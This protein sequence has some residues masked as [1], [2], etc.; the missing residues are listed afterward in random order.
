MPFP[1]IHD[2][3]GI[4]CAVHKRLWDDSSG[5]LFRSFLRFCT[6]TWL[7]TLSWELLGC[8]RWKERI[9]LAEKHIFQVYQRWF[10][11][12]CCLWLFGTSCGFFGSRWF[13]NYF[14]QHQ[15]PRNWNPAHCINR[16]AAGLGNAVLP[17]YADDRCAW[18][19]SE[20]W[21][22]SCESFFKLFY[23]S[24]YCPR[25]NSAPH[26]QLWAASSQLAGTRYTP[27]Y[28]GRYRYAWWSSCRQ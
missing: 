4:R 17:N 16:E 2:D 1:R 21:K 19:L 26:I 14:G 18:R 11:I 8:G 24:A 3:S 25:G 23:V 22:Q 6:G 10:W 28:M 27:W 9:W 5:E 12:G 15:W 7:H 13:E 20:V